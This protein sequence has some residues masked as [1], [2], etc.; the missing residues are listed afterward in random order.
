MMMYGRVKAYKNIKFLKPREAQLMRTLSE[1][2]EPENHL[3][4]F[5]V[6]YTIVFCGCVQ[7]HSREDAHT[8]LKA[9]KATSLINLTDMEKRVLD[10]SHYY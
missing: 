1:Y 8:A 6:S 4:G 3:E 10:T 7:V 5:D 2:L 9:A